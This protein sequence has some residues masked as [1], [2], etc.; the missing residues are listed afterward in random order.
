MD[1]AITGSTTAEGAIIIFFM[2]NAKVIECATVNAVACQ[3]ITYILL[4]NKQRLI[5]NKI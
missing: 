1:K 2:L 3:R 5:T 4:L